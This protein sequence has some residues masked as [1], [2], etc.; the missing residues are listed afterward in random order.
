MLLALVLVI[1]LALASSSVLSLNVARRS[2]QDTRCSLLAR[3]GVNELIARLTKANSSQ[4]IQLFNPRPLDLRQQFPGRCELVPGCWVTFNPSEPG[5]STDNLLGE[6]AAAGWLD[7]GKATRSV[8]P[9]T[10][11]LVLHT[12]LGGFE[13][14]YRALLRRTWPYA[15]YSGAGPVV[16][17]G[18]PEVNSDPAKGSHVTG[19]IFSAV[20]PNLEYE[21]RWTEV[22]R[23]P[24]TA[25]FSLLTAGVRPER[26]YTVPLQVGPDLVVAA[27][28]GAIIPEP[29]PP[30]SP[31]VPQPKRYTI[32][33]PG[34]GSTTVARTKGN[35]VV[36][37]VD[38]SDEQHNRH[39]QALVSD[40]NTFQGQLNYQEP[41]TRR[42]PLSGLAPGST[43]GYQ[44]WTPDGR[45]FLNA[46]M[47][48]NIM[49][50]DHVVVPWPLP[51]NYISPRELL[52]R[53]TWVMWGQHRLAGAAGSPSY[54]VVN[55]NLVNR[56]LWHGVEQVPLGGNSEIPVDQFGF[57]LQLEDCVLHVKGDLDLC[58]VTGTDSSIK[59][60]T[61]NGATIIVEGSLAVT[62]AAIRAGD[63]GMVIYAKNIALAGAG[64]FSGLLVA[65]EGISIVPQPGKRISIRGG[66]VTAGHA[67]N[68]EGRPGVALHNVDVRYDPR[69]MKSLSFCGDYT[70]TA[71]EP[72]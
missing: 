37:S 4:S 35:S 36:G 23:S 57:E 10:L 54:Y 31:D 25:M 51:P 41:T 33:A 49:H 61:G 5:Y 21:L 15:I 46:V 39:R 14:S 47:T 45:S 72:L 8:P 32:R 6:G 9:F 11:E 12:S 38:Y 70:L 58:D 66:I 68:A 13:R 2:Y 42:N 50:Y 22:D 40:G 53:P 44:E 19:R 3:S 65:S 48:G 30:L 17:S 34:N 59:G 7:H 16:L 28:P 27:G 24:K 67:Y 71:W 63:R 52:S 1:G 20:R 29:P 60:I 64:D 56:I 43:S 62:G 18:D 69:Y 55:G 26:D